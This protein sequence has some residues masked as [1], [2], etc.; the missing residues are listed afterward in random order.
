MTPEEF[1]LA[2][3]LVDQLKRIA[4]VLEWYQWKESQRG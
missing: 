1:K 3:E 4:E 2:Q